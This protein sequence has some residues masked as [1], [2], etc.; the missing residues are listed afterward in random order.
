[1]IWSGAHVPEVPANLAQPS[2]FPKIKSFVVPQPQRTAAAIRNFLALVN[3]VDL[4]AENFV[5]LRRTVLEFGRSGIE[6]E[7]WLDQ[8]PYGLCFGHF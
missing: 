4:L 5:W 8:Q 3:S 1:M 6:L 7:N 2:L